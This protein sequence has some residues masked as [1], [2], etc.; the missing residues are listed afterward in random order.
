MKIIHTADWHLGNRLMDRSRAKEQGEFLQWLLE[1]TAKE[2]PDALII[3]G[4]VFDTGTPGEGTREMYHEFLSQ[5]D[6]RGCRQVVVTAGNHDSVAQMESSRPFL[7]R[8]HCQMVTKLVIGE[9]EKGLLEVQGEGG[10]VKG[11]YDPPR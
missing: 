4:D 3:S 10:E 1:L 7:G 5:A 6:E 11:I 8:F 9:E 2:K